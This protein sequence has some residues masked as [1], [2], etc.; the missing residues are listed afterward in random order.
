[1]KKYILYAMLSV[2]LFNSCKKGIDPAPGDR[3]EERTEAALNSYKDA[4]TGN[5]NGWKALLFPSG[6]GVYLFSMKFGTNDRVNMISDFTTA[7][8]STSAESGYRLRLQQSPTLLFDTYSYIHLLADPDPSVA[9]GQGGQGY[10][11]DFEFY[12]DKTSGDTIKLIGNRLGSK[13]F[14]VKAKTAAEY[15]A[16]PKGTND[17]LGKLNQVRTYFKRATIGG[18]DCEVKVNSANKELTFSYLNGNTL[19]SVTGAFYVDGTTMIFL[20]PV[21][22]GTA[23]ITEI[24]G[25]T[26]DATNR[27]FSGTINGTAF[28]LRE[29]ITPLKYDLTAAAT[30]YNSPPNGAY[31]T[32]PAGFTIDGVADAYGVKTIPSFG[33]LLFYPKYNASYSRLGFIVNNAYAAY[34]P[35][36]VASFPV[37]GTIKFTNFG[38]FGTAPTAILPIVTNTTN[39]WYDAGGFYVIKTGVTS[40]DLVS[41]TDAR[42][43][44][45]WGP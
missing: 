6:G 25:V 28:S 20:N 12:F 15:D 14:L 32:S 5:T 4:L 38:S 35:A 44:T 21:T 26:I 17:V 29:S 31:W 40:Y 10:K 8:A 45:S 42:A 37:N 19:T 2:A 18:I 11:S 13:L 30:F 36:P 16:F 27:I 24:K 23:V 3:P 1:M 7:A 34:G 22:I 43:W 39:K 9:G 33:F 41:A